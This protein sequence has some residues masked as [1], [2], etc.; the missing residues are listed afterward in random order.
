[1]LVMKW[2][3]AADSIVKVTFSKSYFFVSQDLSFNINNGK[4][5]MII[6]SERHIDVNHCGDGVF[7]TDYRPAVGDHCKVVASADGFDEIVAETTIPELSEV[8][9]RDM[10][11][12]GNE[13]RVYMH[14]EDI[15]NKNYGYRITTFYI[16]SYVSVSTGDT[17]YQGNYVLGTTDPLLAPSQS[18]FDEGY[19]NY[20]PNDKFKD[21]AIDFYVNVYLPTHYETGVSYKL[22]YISVCMETLTRGLY[23]YMQSYDAY[24]DAMYNPFAEPVQVYSNVVGGMGIIESKS[25][26][27][28]ELY[29]AMPESYEDGYWFIPM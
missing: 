2:S 16:T 9:L 25:G 1:M 18:I 7:R 26:N 23:N 13:V 22:E 27:M 19:I 17:I 6:N 28:I 5:S 29:G 20:F 8:S 11:R 12:M 15:K 3:L 21:G 24:Y 14:L 10:K 4:V